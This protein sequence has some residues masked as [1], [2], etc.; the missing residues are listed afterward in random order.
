MVGLPQEIMP[1]TEQK[2]KCGLTFFYQD[3]RQITYK[4]GYEPDQWFGTGRL[5]QNLQGICGHGGP[6]TLAAE[7]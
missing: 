6:S 2:C 4:F 7:A 5:L 3:H 1:V